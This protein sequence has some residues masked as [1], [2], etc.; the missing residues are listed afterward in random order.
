M[1]RVLAFL[2]LVTN[3]FSQEG[4]ASNSSAEQ[5]TMSLDST[6]PSTAPV[7]VVEGFKVVLREGR[8]PGRKKRYSKMRLSPID[9]KAQQKLSQKV[10]LLLDAA[11]GDTLSLEARKS[12]D[13]NKDKISFTWASMS[14]VDFKQQNQTA[15]GFR[16]PEVM[17]EQIFLFKLTL[18]DGRYNT[19]YFVGIKAKPGQTAVFKGIKHQVVQGGDNVQ[20]S[21]VGSGGIR[22]KDLSYL[23]RAPDGIA[24]SSN[25]EPDISFKVPATDTDSHYILFLAVSGPTGEV[26]D[27]SLIHI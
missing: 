10:D 20:I 5:D 3:I 23:W 1:V 16:I 22:N 14:D 24:L 15:I 6:I 7:A 18:N 21:A 9:A 8:I 12:Y 26:V 11:S 27:L 19:E 25:T 2:L 13:E 4:G 17:F